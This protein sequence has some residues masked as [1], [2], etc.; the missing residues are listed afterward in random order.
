MIFISVF[1][2]GPGLEWEQTWF[3]VGFHW[4][5]CGLEKSRSTFTERYAKPSNEIINHRGLSKKK[6]S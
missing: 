1:W 2:A 5:T 4:G 3:P 6:P